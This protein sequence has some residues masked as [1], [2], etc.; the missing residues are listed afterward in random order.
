MRE[1]RGEERGEERESV[2][3]RG[4]LLSIIHTDVGAQCKQPMCIMTLFFCQ[5]YLLFLGG[6][7]GPLSCFSGRGLFV[8]NIPPSVLDLFMSYWP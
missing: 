6:T 3:M 1:K 5:P 8:F 2:I 4:G 7:G